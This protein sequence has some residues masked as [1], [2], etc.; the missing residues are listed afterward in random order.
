MYVYY[1][2]S[3]L[4]HTPLVIPALYPR[5]KQYQTLHS[6]YDNKNTQ[7]Y[8]SILFSLIILPFCIHISESV[9]RIEL[10]TEI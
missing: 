1:L 3:Q 8:S 4:L 9:T 2:E 6:T 10:I 5:G 7:K